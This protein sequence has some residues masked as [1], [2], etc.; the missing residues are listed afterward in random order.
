MVHHSIKDPIGMAYHG[1]EGLLVADIFLGHSL[2]NIEE[3]KLYS[4]IETD[5]R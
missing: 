5:F 1:Q 3:R 4:P 2:K